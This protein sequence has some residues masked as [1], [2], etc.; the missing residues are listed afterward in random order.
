MDELT[1]AGFGAIASALPGLG[2]GF[3]MLSGKWR[4]ASA[5]AA[6]DPG[7]ARAVEGV[8]LVV[9]SGLIALLG[10]L[11]LVLPEETSR[12]IAP[13]F[14]GLVLGT[15]VLGLIPFFRAHRS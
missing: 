9:I 10:L 6:R 2:F 13:W 4:S 5:A 12:A 15:T 11:F 1:F 8:F 3:A 14:I 7:R